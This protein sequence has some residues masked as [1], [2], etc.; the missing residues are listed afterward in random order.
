MTPSKPEYEFSGNPE[1]KLEKLIF[2]MIR[3]GGS[4]STLTDDVLDIRARLRTLE[5]DRHARAVADARA[6]ER[7]KNLLQEMEYVKR[8]LR[9]LKGVLNKA[10]AVI[11]GAILLAVVKWVLD[12]N[13]GGL[14]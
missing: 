3:H 1:S 8:S 12:G 6:E 4:I 13:L 14:S 5:E 7:D 11:F 10:L 2:Y 9:D